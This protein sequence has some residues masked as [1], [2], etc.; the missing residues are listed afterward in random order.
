MD[1]FCGY[2]QKTQ[3]S[4]RIFGG[5]AGKYMSRF[6]GFVD[7]QERIWWLVYV[8][9]QTINVLFILSNMSYQPFQLRQNVYGEIT[10]RYPQQIFQCTHTF[11]IIASIKTNHNI[12]ILRLLQLFFFYHNIYV[13]QTLFISYIRKWSTIQIVFKVYIYIQTYASIFNDSILNK[14]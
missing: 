4:R 12:Y 13:F 3:A 8:N 10:V 1:R 9:Q 5:C 2:V 11:N 6:G 14:I 7:K